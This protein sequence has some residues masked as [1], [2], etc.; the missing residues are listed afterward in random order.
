MDI[1]IYVYVYV[2]PKINEH[3]EVDVIYL[4][5]NVI[6]PG[7]IIRGSGEILLENFRY[8]LGHHQSRKFRKYTRRYLNQK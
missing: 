6:V 7:D 4:I 2:K 8:K 1:G 5:M 3:R